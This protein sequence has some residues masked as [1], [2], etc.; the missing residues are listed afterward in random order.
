MARTDWMRYPAHNFE[1]T[2]IMMVILRDHLKVEFRTFPTMDVLPIGEQCEGD[3]VTHYQGTPMEYK[4]LEER[5]K[6][7]TYVGRLQVSCRTSGQRPGNPKALDMRV[8]LER[9]ESLD[10]WGNF[11]KIRIWHHGLR[12]SEKPHKAAFLYWVDQRKLVSDD[13]L[14]NQPNNPPL[15]VGFSHPRFKRAA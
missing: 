14:R 13:R 7:N 11:W 4:R 2:E 8:Q 3:W 9:V 5:F 12:H 6:I 10:G 15:E 1:I